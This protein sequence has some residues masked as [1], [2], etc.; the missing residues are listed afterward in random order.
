MRTLTLIFCLLSAAGPAHAMSVDQVIG[1]SR[2]G[3]SASEIIRRMDTRRVTFRLQ[4]ADIARLRLAGVQTAVI[5]HMRD[6]RFLYGAAVHPAAQ[7]AAKAARRRR[8]IVE[9]RA[10]EVR[11]EALRSQEKTGEGIAIAGVAVMMVSGVVLLLQHAN[12]DKHP[13]NYRPMGVAALVG[14]TASVIGLAL[15]PSDDD[16]LDLERH[17]EDTRRRLRFSQPRTFSLPV[18]AGQF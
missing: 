13:Q 4:S 2:Q 8:S 17:I 10:A 3:V 18:A 16:I 15:M 7:K 14:G 11:L 9:V 12:S 1:W 5:D 6:S